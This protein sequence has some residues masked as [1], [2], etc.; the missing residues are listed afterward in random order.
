MTRRIDYITA[1]KMSRA[2]LTRES[3]GIDAAFDAALI[4]GV[5]PPLAAT[6]LTRAVARIEFIVQGDRSDRRR[7]QRSR[8]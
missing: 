5:L 2:L 3:S 1:E 7:E 6:I 4:E 8:P